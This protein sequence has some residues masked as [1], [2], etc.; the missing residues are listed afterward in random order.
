MNRRLRRLGAIGT[1]LVLLCLGIYCLVLLSSKQVDV[2]LVELLVSNPV[3]PNNWETDSGHLS[4]NWQRSSEEVSYG[5]SQNFSFNKFYSLSNLNRCWTN[6][7]AETALPRIC[8]GVFLYNSPL[9]AEL[10]YWLSRP[11]LAYDNKW[12]DFVYPSE[13]TY[14]SDLAHQEHVVCAMGRP[15][16][17]QVWFYWARYGQY[18]LEIEFVAFKGGTRSGLFAQIVQQIDMHMAQRLNTNK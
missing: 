9:E 6:G 4:V 10:R 3:F 1:G 13:W 14:Q 5:P 18:I 8:Q 11:E 17:C 7:G 2:P 12:P 15:D 16:D